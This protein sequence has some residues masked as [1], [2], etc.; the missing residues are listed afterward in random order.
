MKASDFVL[1]FSK[2]V[3]QMHFYEKKTHILNPRVTGW[4]FKIGGNEYDFRDQH[5]KN[6]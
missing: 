6:V 4:V 5:R 2:C 1:K 3:K